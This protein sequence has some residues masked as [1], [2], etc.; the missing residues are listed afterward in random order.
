MTDH[1]IPDKYRSTVSADGTEVDLA[2]LAQRQVPEWLSHQTQ[3]RKLDLHGNRLTNLPDWIAGLTNLTDLNLEGNRLPELPDWIGRLTN[4]KVLRLSRNQLVQLPSAVGTLPHLRAL[5]LSFMPLRSLPDSIGD[6]ENLVDLDITANRQIHNLPDSFAK[7]TS[8]KLLSLWSSGLNSFPDWIGNF[9]NLIELSMGPWDLHLLPEAFRNLTSLRRLA[10]GNNALET[11]P[12]WV[13]ELDQ[14]RTLYLWENHLTILPESFGNLVR[15]VILNLRDNSLTKLPQ[16]F[17]KLAYLKTLQIQGNRISRLPVSF[18]NLTSLKSID[19]GHNNFTSLPASISKLRQ[20]ETL[21]IESNRLASLPAWLG[22]LTALTKLTAS[23]NEFGTIPTIVGQLTRLKELDLSNNC[24]TEL[25]TWI[26]DLNHLAKLDVSHNALVDAPPSVAQLS[27]LK[28]F[29]LDHNPLRSPLQ[30]LSADGFP[31]VKAYLSEKAKDVAE[32]WM[33]KLLIVGEGAVGKTSLVKALREEQYDPKEQTTHGIKIREI[34][35]SHPD[36][37]DVQMRLSSWDF[38]G[39]DI[40][41]ATHQFFLTDR[42]LFL[43]LW[44]S[45]QGW[46]QAKIPYWLDI[47]K[48]RAPHSRVILVATY[49]EGRPVDLPLNDL[50]ELYPQ[51]AASTAVDN[52]TTEGV[53]QLRY[54]MATEAIK[55]PLMGS[56][57]PASWVR[58][59]QVIAA[60]EL[61]YAKPAHLASLLAK[62]GIMPASAQDYLLRALH[63]LGEILYFDEDEDLCDTVIIHP[64]WV[65]EY[66]AKILDSPDVAS[67]HGLLTR[68]HM[69]ELWTDLDPILQDRFLLLMER[70]DLS[71]RIQDDIRA[72][73]LVV[74]RLP[75]DSPPYV[76]SWERALSVPGAGEI[77]LLYRLNTL[78]PGVPT[79]FIARE[80][81]FRTDIQWRG[82]ALLRYSGDSR[83]LGLIR[84]ERQDG[85]VELAVRGPVPQLFFSVLQDGFESTLRRYPGLEVT[86]LVPCTC[87]HGDDVGNNARC[88]HLYL[89]DPLLKRV[90]KG[91]T[92]V[93]C[94]LSFATVPV[95]KLL[96]GIAPTVAED[97]LLRL[98]NLGLHVEQIGHGIE[99]LRAE[100]AWAQ[101]EF[102]KSLRGFQ[103]RYEAICPSLFTVT[104]PK[105]RSRVP[106][107]QHLEVHLC[108]EQPGALHLVSEEPYVVKDAAKWLMKLST[109]LVILVSVLKHAAPLA[110]PLLGVTAEQLSKRLQ[111]QTDLM[112]ALISDL[113]GTVPQQVSLFENQEAGGRVKLDVDYRELYAFLQALDPKER[114]GGLS[115]VVTPEDQVLWLCRE[116]ASQ[117]LA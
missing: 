39:Q 52:R 36:R 105:R 89:Y 58:G 55:L 68:A 50:K 22:N 11:L 24:L 83:V 108:C 17:G 47:I 95:A 67:R 85:M 77:R 45:R 116:H 2:G 69:R 32:L 63:M 86:R 81:R 5:H 3:V 107:L 117:F 93:E 59:T 49:C 60:C 88:K 73:S 8:L 10:A 43:L 37:P 12:D 40:Y 33:S 44:N 1:S 76:A 53:A 103:A 61:Q 6:L 15:L 71:Y 51:I 18:G 48:A 101:R 4:L 27:K 75:W 109:Y 102:L 97:L 31:A 20:L 9:A 91:I 62:A 66:I 26:G 16:S 41:H 114:W 94:Q 65:N 46:E 110:G 90:E 92:G 115:R 82:G 106:G 28:Y 113:P 72:A 98:D 57:W 96:F 25:P 14:L 70:F 112:A 99:K 74:E 78:P 30:E 13:G 64:Q 38:G 80:H 111:D 54:I 29:A 100:T 19:M 79:W 104:V 56:E 34:N 87:E 21:D 35:L 84:V 23:D 42:S 7:L